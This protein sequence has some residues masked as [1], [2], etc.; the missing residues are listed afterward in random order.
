MTYD[1]QTIDTYLTQKTSLRISDNVRLEHGNFM[2]IKCPKINCVA[3]K[4][5][6]LRKDPYFNHFQIL[7][8]ILNILNIPGNIKE[9]LPILICVTDIN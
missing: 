1:F 8:E 7:H 4:F 5:F 9:R 2:Y 3:P 6:L